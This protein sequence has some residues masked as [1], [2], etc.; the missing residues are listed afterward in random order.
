MNHL[1]HIKYLR[2]FTKI[3]IFTRHKGKNDSINQML[4]S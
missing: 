1:T 4:D 3:D 2:V